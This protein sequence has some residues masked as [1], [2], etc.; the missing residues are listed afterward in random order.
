MTA[1]RRSIIFEIR[2][3]K[4]QGNLFKHWSDENGNIWIQAKVSDP[5]KEIDPI[6]WAGGN[7]SHSD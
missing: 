4:K 7:L 3:L 6:L 1:R 2:Q 5:K